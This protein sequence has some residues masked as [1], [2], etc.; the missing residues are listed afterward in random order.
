MS[1]KLSKAQWQT[2]YNS[3]RPPQEFDPHIVYVLFL[4]AD[5][6]DPEW[7]FF[8]TA[9]DYV[10][11][12]L[13]PSPCYTHVELVVPG[14]A[15]ELQHFATY[16]GRSGKWGTADAFKDGRNFYLDKKRNGKSWRAVPIVLPDAAA[17]LR[18]EC[19]LNEVT[20]YGLWYRLYNYPFSAP[21]LRNLAWALSDERKAPAHC[22]A[23]T[24]RC[25]K[26][27]FPELGLAHPSAWYSPTTL[28]LE[29]TSHA[30]TV[31]SRNLLMANSNNSNSNNDGSDNG[32]P[33]ASP[34]TPATRPGA[35]DD[36]T[37][38]RVLLFESDEAVAAL[39]E[40]QAQAGIRALTANVLDAAVGGDVHTETQARHRLA[41][42][43]L[44][45]S[46]VSRS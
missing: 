20:P 23:L 43:L 45:W 31:A 44:R 1:V 35:E 46:V 11:Q 26:N 42:G 39:S 9:I 8:E 40:Q 18:R 41:R 28:F 14:S 37:A 19:T 25:L 16:L 36:G 33:P 24:A 7:S 3:K 10:V 22:G 4:A 5:E 32:T 27:C 12:T 15:S 30:N 34:P 2:L 38:M 13:Q 29:L 21:P 17:R 6:P